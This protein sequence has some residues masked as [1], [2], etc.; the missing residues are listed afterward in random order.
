MGVLDTFNTAL[1]FV[2]KPFLLLPPFWAIVMLSFFIA[3]LTTLIYKWTTNQSVMKELKQEIKTLQEQ[4]KQLKEQPDKAME[5]HKKVMET[6]MQYM[7]HS[8]KPT[9]I[10]FLPI[11]IIFGWMQKNFA[12][13]GTLL[14]L[15]LFQLG[16]LGTYILFSIIFSILLR[17][18]LKLH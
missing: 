2:L 10:T 8:M 13:A 17:K 5:I 11:I 12:T 14:D 4:A 9:L 1:H 16:W 7:S 3:L 15:R 18:L 6:N